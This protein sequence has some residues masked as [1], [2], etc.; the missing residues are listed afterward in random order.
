[1]LYILAISAVVLG[2]WAEDS[3]RDRSI[4]INIGLR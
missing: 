2:Y 1:M 3:F 4:G